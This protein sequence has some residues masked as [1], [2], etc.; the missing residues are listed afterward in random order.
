MDIALQEQAQSLSSKI[1]HYL[2]TTMG[3]TLDEA[4]PEEFYRAFSL[5]LREEIMIAWT[6]S[7]YTYKKRR[8]RML[9]YLCMEYMPGRFLG[10]NVSNIHAQDLVR[11]VMKL[12]GRDFAEEV[13]YEPDAGLGNG[14]LGRL[15]ACFLDSLATQKYPAIAYGLRF[16]YGIFEQ[17]I[18]NGSQVERPEN[19][20]LHE[21]PWEYRRDT[22]AN[23][24]WYAGRVVN[25][26]NHTCD[27]IWDVIDYDEVR[28]LAYDIPILGIKRT[29]ALMSIRCAS[30][31]LKSLHATSNC[32]GIMQDFLIRRLKIR[33]SLMFYI[34][35]IT[36]R[37]VNGSD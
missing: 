34:P 6:A 21:C 14:G 20:L 35:M 11:Y 26:K 27:D 7:T 9:Y 8:A 31:R 36:T 13:S 2:I 3:V 37:P 30:G 18:W 12:M 29:G 17:E 16:Q 25:T 28:A 24:V 15:A 33:C 5:T 4:S 23:S 32:S 22:H 19:W 1:K 10:N